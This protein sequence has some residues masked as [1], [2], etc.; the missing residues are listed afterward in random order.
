M[1]VFNKTYDAPPVD[2]QEVLR[3]AGCSKKSFD[4]MSVLEECIKECENIFTYR[5]CY[6]T[7]PAKEENGVV[8]L[9]FTRQKSSSLLQYINGCKKVVVFAATIGIEIDRLI[10]KYGQ[11]SPSKAVFFQ[12]IGAERIEAL[13]DVFCED[14]KADCKKEGL[15]TKTRFSPGYGDFPLGVQREIFNSLDCFK[16]IGLSLNENFLMSPS[17]SVTALIAVSSK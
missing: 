2:I 4:I 9:T 16:K 3:Y 15:F 8:D 5:V 17:K 10:K 7:F 6:A 1:T 11:V 13:C 12:A 14:I